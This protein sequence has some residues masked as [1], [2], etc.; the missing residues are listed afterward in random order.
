MC[1]RIE[2]AVRTEVSRHKVA[3]SKESGRNVTDSEARADWETRHGEE[4]RADYQ[5]QMLAL[6]REEMLK[7][8]WIES[9]KAQRDLGRDAILDWINKYAAHWRAWYEAESDLRT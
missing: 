5:A 3:L 9:E 4:W 2:R 6:Q 8:K 1:S 7:Y